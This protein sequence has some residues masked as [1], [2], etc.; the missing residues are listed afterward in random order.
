MTILNA[1]RLFTDSSTDYDFLCN[2]T[3]QKTQVN[4]LRA[5]RDEIRDTLK[6][7]C[8]GWQK[9]I[10]SAMLFENA[11]FAAASNSL[12]PKFRMQGSMAYNTLNKPAQIPQ[13]QID[14]DDGLFLPVSFYENGGVN[15][16]VIAMTGIF[17][18]VESAL[19]PMCERR[20]WKLR[21]KATC[22]RVELD[23]QSHVDIAIYAIPDAEF[24]RMIESMA[25]QQ[26]A[27]PNLLLEATELESR[28]YE[29][30]RDDQIMLAHRE[31]GWKPSDPRKLEKWFQD[32][33]NEFGPQLRRVCRYFKAWRDAEWEKCS[34]SSIALMK[35]VVDV[36]KRGHEFENKR[37]DLAIQTVANQLPGLFGEQIENPVVDGQYLDESWTDI[38]RSDFIR[39]AEQLIRN[40]EA[41]LGAGQADRVIQYMKTGFGERIPDDV[42]LIRENAASAA[43]LSGL[44]AK[45]EISHAVIKEKGD[46]YA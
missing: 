26:E 28:V 22:V 7:A 20:G 40:V 23:S 46:R 6:S 3:L 36:Y 17:R 34:L 21:Q 43:V 30:L 32:A 37:D 25:R 35:C 42:N 10:G 18:L 4:S 39:G 1:H 8:S 44:A 5:A 31:E 13:Q 41:A 24:S 11:T 29:A 33:V 15:T 16:P 9:H 38:D 45:S 14:V 19:E 27:D 2:I 12:R